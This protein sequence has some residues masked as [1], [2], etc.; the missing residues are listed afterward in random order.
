MRRLILFLVVL[1]P[2]YSYAQDTT[3]TLPTADTS[4]SF[5]VFKSDYSSV[6]KARADGNVGIGRDN[7]A[8]ALD[9][10][11]TVQATAFAG[12]GSALTGVLHAVDADTLEGLPV[13]RIKPRAAAVGGHQRAFLKRVSPAGACFLVWR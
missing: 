4:S 12:N 1:A 6:L 8:T 9:V 13:N 3:V 2:A 10:N 5:I 11:G 7:P